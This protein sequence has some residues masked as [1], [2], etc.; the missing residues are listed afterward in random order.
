M[1]SEK[2]VQLSKHT[3]HSNVTQYIACSGEFF[4]R[5]V[6]NSKDRDQPIDQQES[7]PDKDIGGGPPHEAPPEDPKLY[8]LIIDNE[9]VDN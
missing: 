3:M 1:E 9:Y 4:I 7:H 8:E 5:R 2:G 6:R